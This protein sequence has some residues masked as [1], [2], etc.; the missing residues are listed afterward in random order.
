MN[1]Y[2][3]LNWNW[4]KSIQKQIF[5]PHKKYPVIEDFPIIFRTVIIMIFLFRGIFF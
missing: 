3:R 1:D 4:V 5:I 2:L